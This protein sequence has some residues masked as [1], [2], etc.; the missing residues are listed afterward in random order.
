M[1]SK[2]KTYKVSDWLCPICDSKNILFRRK[3]KDHWC[4]RC[5]SNFIL[6]KVKSK[7]GRICV[8]V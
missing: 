8:E 5:G 6:K 4:R 3:T 2:I 7:K 1:A